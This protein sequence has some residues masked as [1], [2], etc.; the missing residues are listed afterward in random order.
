MRYV[1]AFE[2]P[3]FGILVSAFVRGRGDLV[4]EGDAGGV[5]LDV[6]TGDRVW[7]GCEDGEGGGGGGKCW[8]LWGEEGEVVGVVR[9]MIYKA[10]FVGRERA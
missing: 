9:V 7:G 5:G 10:M 4:W 8:I 2:I 6:G 3:G 1:N